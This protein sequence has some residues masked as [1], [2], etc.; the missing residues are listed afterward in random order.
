MLWVFYHQKGIKYENVH[1]EKCFHLMSIPSTWFPV[2]PWFL[3]SKHYKILLFTFFLHIYE[4]QSH[5][6]IYSYRYLP[7]P[8]KP[9]I[10]Y[11][12]VLTLSFSV[13][14]MYT[15][16][17]SWDQH[18]E[19][20]LLFYSCRPTTVKALIALKTHWISLNLWKRIIT[21]LIKMLAKAMV[22]IILQ[23]VSESNQHLKVTQSY[24]SI[25]YQ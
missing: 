15:L 6:H 25:I 3:R 2:L 10:F 5:T 21:L 12:L 19:M 14:N 8:I 16:E 17:I 23:Y 22:V 1:W 20:F 7:P 24:M 11:I 18:I 9:T 13:N 4:I